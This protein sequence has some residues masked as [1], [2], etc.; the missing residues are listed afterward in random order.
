MAFQRAAENYYPNIHHRIRWVDL[1]QNLKVSLNSEKHKTRIKNVLLVVKATRSAS[2]R[3][4]I[5]IQ[6]DENPV[7]LPRSEE[8]LASKIIRK[9]LTRMHVS[10]TRL[11]QMGVHPSSVFADAPLL[12]AIIVRPSQLVT[13]FLQVFHWIGR[14]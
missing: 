9:V 4:N 2:L 13:K 5:S 12:L 3:T 14:R 10:I 1:D 8:P 6:N 11:L 7:Q